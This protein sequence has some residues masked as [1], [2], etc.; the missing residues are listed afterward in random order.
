[1]PGFPVHHRVTLAHS[2]C[3]IPIKFPWKTNLIA[4][5]FIRK[6]RPYIFAV[7]EIHVSTTGLRIIQKKDRELKV[8]IS[9]CS[10]F[11]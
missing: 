5:W 8:F 10:I 1:M 4:Y 9:E 11:H 6:L 3:L 2:L 7:L